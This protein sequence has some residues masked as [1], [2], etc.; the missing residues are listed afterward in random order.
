MSDMPFL[1]VPPSEGKQPGAQPGRRKDSFSKA[2]ALPR[3][4][5]R[6]A[7]EKEITSLS[8]KR[9]EKLFKAKGDLLNRARTVTTSF[10]DGTAPMMPA[11]AR[12]SGVV[13]EHLDPASLE[14]RQRARLLIPSAVYGV[15][16][17][18]DSIADYRLTMLVGLS[19]LGNLGS[20]WRPHV[21]KALAKAAKGQVIVDLL[22]KEHA[23]AVDFE[24]LGDIA[25]V[26]HIRFVSADGKSA[27]GHAAKAVKGTVARTLADRG[28]SR[29]KSFSWE[30]WTVRREGSDFEVIA[31]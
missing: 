29:L 3:H 26:V 9:A 27:A 23:N 28:L 13:W 18:T 6:N 11:W 17:G 4:E 24:V 31:P 12:Y 5:L 1:L 21:T 2:L 25:E 7:L 20:W 22:P 10:L 16:T 14:D 15:T 8:E 30:G 19:M